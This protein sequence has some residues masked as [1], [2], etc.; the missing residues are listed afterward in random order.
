MKGIKKLLAWG[1]AAAVL[2]SGVQMPTSTVKAE[3]AGKESKIATVKFDV[4]VTGKSESETSF[5]W[6]MASAN[7]SSRPAI[8]V[9]LDQGNGD[10]SFEQTFAE[11]SGLINL[12]Y[13]SES[14][15][16]NSEM[17]VTINKI[18]VNGY[19]MTYETAPTVYPVE[20][21]GNGI[22]NI[23]GQYADGA[24]ICSGEDAYLAFYEGAEDT[25]ESCDDLIKLYVTNGDVIG[26][27]ED[28]EVI[29]PSSKSIDYVKA[30]GSGWNL[31]N[32]FEGYDS[33]LSKEDLLETTWGNPVVAKE[34]IQ[35]VKAKGYKSIRM[36]FTIYRRYT[37]KENPGEGE[38]KYVINE[39][40]LKRYKEVVDWAVEEGMYV[41][42][43][44]HCDS[45]SWLNDWDGS[46]DSEEYRM[47]TDFWK[48]LADYMS[49]EPEQVCFEAINEPEYTDT[50]DENGNVT[51]TAQDKLDTIN[52]AAYDIIR[53][54]EGNETRM[55]VMQT[56]VAR[57]G[58]EYCKPVKELIESLNDENVIASIHYYSEWVYSANL[59]IT[60][61][62]E[63]LWKVNGE[64]YTAR[65]SVDDVMNTT[66]KQFTKNGIGVIFGEYGLLGYDASEGCLQTGEELKYNELFMEEARSWSN[67]RSKHGRTFFL[68]NR[69]EYI[70]FYSRGYSGCTDSTYIKWQYLCGNRGT[71]SRNRLHL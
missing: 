9:T 2:V 39:E 15:I 42:I 46:T 70:I 23:W 13:L 29:I 1:M 52:K 48:Q 40:W 11:T 20:A 43:N 35:A 19:E 6:N 49:D 21:K 17:A 27:D 66:Y 68:F 64:S 63:E 36:P 58:A 55:I 3:T 4:T 56:M 53:D 61:F 26:D 34:L 54:T 41:M 30:M 37:V 38:Y 69:I 18:T 12:G 10:Y 50:T 44:I 32:S 62:D 8:V 47:Y 33:D 5:T 28:E 60:S 14:E 7:W 59:G 65:D 16:E 24:V 45:V 57:W 67:A 22:S 51:I 71:D 31:G 25:E